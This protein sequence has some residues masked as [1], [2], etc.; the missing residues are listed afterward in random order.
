VTPRVGVATIADSFSSSR[1]EAFH[2][3]GGRHDYIDQRGQSFYNW[4]QQ[5]NVGSGSTGALTAPADPE[6]DRYLF[7]N[8][9]S[10]AYYVQSSF[11]SDEGYGFLLD[12]DEISHWRM[13]SDR[14]DAWQVE[15]GA[16]KLD[17]TVMPGSPKRA[18]AA[19]SQLNGRHRVPPKWA[20][21]SLLVRSVN[22]PD[23]TPA[24]YLARVR[25]DIREIEKTGTPVDA[26]GIEGWEF[27]S[28][29]ELSGV[30][31]DLRALGIDALLPALRWQGRDRH[32]RPGRL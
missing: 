7:P 31:A 20:Q 30:V 15:V 13:A 10:A 23:D 1:D 29:S 21:G 26:Y 6:R 19:I 3:F 8:G 14:D 18:A 24:G 12:R 5:Q 4:L 22:F 17:Y 32:R 27:L 11:V 28:D 2:G 9:S 25:D 16:G